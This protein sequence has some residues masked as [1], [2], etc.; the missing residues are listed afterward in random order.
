MYKNQS[1][2]IEHNFKMHNPDNK[3]KARYVCNDCGMQ[4]A[5][6]SKYDRHTRVHRD[7]DYACKFCG[8][9]IKSQENLKYHENTHTGEQPHK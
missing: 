5:G 4:F 9:K 1:S 6:K 7:G 2:Y 3:I 8:K